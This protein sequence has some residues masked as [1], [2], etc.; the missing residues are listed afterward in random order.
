MSSGDQISPIFFVFFKFLHWATSA[1]MSNGPVVTQP[2][3][4]VLDRFL[5]CR[6][7]SDWLYILVHNGESMVNHGILMVNTLIGGLNFIFHFIY[8]MSSF[9][10]DSYFS[11]NLNHQP[12]VFAVLFRTCLL[13][14]Y[15]L[16]LC[17]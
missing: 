10:F 8:A 15:T 11:E 16:H 13:M 3:A 2:E 9:A 17:A 4:G 5:L 14:V 7:M 12:D 1:A 6:N